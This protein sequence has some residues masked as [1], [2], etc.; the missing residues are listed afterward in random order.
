ML[1]DYRSGRIV[2]GEEGLCRKRKDVW[3]DGR[4]KSKSGVEQ[5]TNRKTQ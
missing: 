2:E 1:D 5:E 4:T 3:E